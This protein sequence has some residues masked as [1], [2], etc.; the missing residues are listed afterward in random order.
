[1]TKEHFNPLITV[2]SKAIAKAAN[3]QEE[4]VIIALIEHAEEDFRYFNIP[5]K[6]EKLQQL[7]E[8]LQAKHEENNREN[9]NQSACG[10]YVH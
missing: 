1:M 7:R 3:Q 10:I 5:G 9:Q 8:E 6:D 2:L 4:Q